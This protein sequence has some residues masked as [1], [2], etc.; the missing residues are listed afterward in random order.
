MGKIGNHVSDFIFTTGFTTTNIEDS[1]KTIEAIKET[2][3][4]FSTRH[5]IKL[6]LEE[7]EIT[8]K[9]LHEK[10]TN[11]MS[12]T[13]TIHHRPK[14]QT[15]LLIGGGLMALSYIGGLLTGNGK[16]ISDLQKDDQAIQMALRKKHLHC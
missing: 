7:E 4:H 6:N 8:L 2:I 9:T 16:D 11:L 5:D 15:G 13:G 1:I 3:K 10:Y 14:R 12:S